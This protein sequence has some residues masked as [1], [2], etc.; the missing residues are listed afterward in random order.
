MEWTVVVETSRSSHSPS[1]F[2]MGW[3]PLL[4]TIFLS[5]SFPFLP[6]FCLFIYFCFSSSLQSFP[7][8]PSLVFLQVPLSP[9]LPVLLPRSLV[10]P[11]SVHLLTFPVVLPPLP[12]FYPFPPW[13]G[14]NN[15]KRIIFYGHNKCRFKPLK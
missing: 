1:S 13:V 10:S 12:S 2:G 6:S 5:F 14:E 3:V 15:A 4:L 8:S 7:L 9:L 11:H